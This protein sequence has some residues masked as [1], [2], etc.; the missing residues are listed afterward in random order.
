MGR[1]WAERR[2]REKR[3]LRRVKNISKK[4]GSKRDKREKE[5]GGEKMTWRRE[6]EK[7]KEEEIEKMKRTLKEKEEEMERLKA[8]E[9]VK[10]VGEGDGRV[11]SRRE[12][13][14]SDRRNRGRISVE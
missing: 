14:N 6:P 5:R 2:M 12:K 7:L 10:E 8:K 3:R 11:E 4:S 9:V 13:K 1:P